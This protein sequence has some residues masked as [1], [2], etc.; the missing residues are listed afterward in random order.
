MM[1]ID[2]RRRLSA[3]QERL[4]FLQRLTGASGLYNEYACARISGRLNMA[5]MCQA[6]TEIMRRHESLRWVVQDDRGSCVAIA[7]DDPF[8]DWLQIVNLDQIT[9][10]PERERMY[11]RYATEATQ[12]PFDLTA[13]PLCRVLLFRF[14][15]C[16]F[17]IAVVMHH[18]ISDAWSMHIL[19]EDLCRTYRTMSCGTPGAWAEADYNPNCGSSTEGDEHLHYWI[20]K[21]AHPPQPV[22]LPI[23]RPWPAVRTFA[24]AKK[25][26]TLEA[27]ASA[28]LRIRTREAH[29]TS[30]IYLL[31]LW[32]AYLGMVA[33][34]RD[35]VIGTTTGGR[36]DKGTERLIGFFVNTLAIRTEI[37]PSDSFTQYLKQVRAIT[38]DALDHREARF[39]RVVQVLQLPRQ[40]NRQPLFEVMFV[41]VNTPVLDLALEG[42]E[43]RLSPEDIA[44]GLSKFGLVISFWE[45]GTSI[46]GLID[47]S[48]EL[49]DSSEIGAHVTQFQQF[50]SRTVNQP[51]QPLS[52]LL[53]TSRVPLSIVEELR[54]I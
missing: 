32:T 39:E 46:R 10:D 8:P 49:Y 28:S 45:D 23:H 40:P 11:R 30:F 9:D 6:L 44:V 24:G 18:I 53:S 47:Y 17:A 12:L 15:Q 31:A 51:D 34:A 21:L 3:G 29:M 33:G 16:K 37:R 35:L 26:F 41:Y 27:N 5:A 22:L 52:E 50:V 2:R 25:Y 43:V 13:G 4:W 38:L 7:R 20:E 42:V 48:L 14:S 19:V 36:H 1:S 54:S